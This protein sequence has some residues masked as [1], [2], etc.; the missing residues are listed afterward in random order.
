MIQKNGSL[1][2]GHPRTPGL[3][4]QV[5]VPRPVHLHSRR[6]MEEEWGGKVH[7]Q[8]TRCVA[9]VGLSSRT[10]GEVLLFVS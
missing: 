2:M 4:R 6:R 5:W 3:H 10:L 8:G 1:L 7:R 9:F